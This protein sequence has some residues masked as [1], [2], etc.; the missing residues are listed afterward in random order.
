MWFH[1]HLKSNERKVEWDYAHNA[2]KHRR[3]QKEFRSEWKNESAYDDTGEQKGLWEMGKKRKRWITKLY[4]D[5]NQYF[6]I[7]MY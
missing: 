2:V 6:L 7:V 1:V 5:S 3:V 4:T